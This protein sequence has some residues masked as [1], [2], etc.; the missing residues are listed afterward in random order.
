[1]RIPR[2]MALISLLSLTACGSIDAV[3]TNLQSNPP[4]HST[5]PHTTYAAPTLPPAYTATPTITRTPRPSITPTPFIVAALEPS[6]TGGTESLPAPTIASAFGPWERVE[7]TY[8]DI[9]V[10]I[11]PGTSAVRNGRSL[12]ISAG[13]VDPGTP[14]LEIELRVDAAIASRFPQGVDPTNALSVLD[15]MLR[16][17]ESSQTILSVIRPSKEAALGDNPG[18]SAAIRSRYAN[19]EPSEVTLWY[20]AAIVHQEETVVRILAS[21][22]E[23]AGV[24]GLALAERVAGS[25]RFLE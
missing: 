3:G 24:T 20:L 11:P 2:L 1:M 15:G 22:P 21:T 17:V 14:A 7:D 9:S 12:L 13:E 10:E 6:P 25:V 23:S 8:L 4:P 16:D 19:D 5:E 18:A